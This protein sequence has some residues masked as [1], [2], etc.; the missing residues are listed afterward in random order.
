MWLSFFYRQLLETSQC[1]FMKNITLL[2]INARYTH[3]NLALFYMREAIVDLP[4]KVNLSEESINQDKFKILANL[5]ETEPQIVAIS[6]YIWNREIVEFLLTSL[7]KINPEI[8]VVL[9]GPEA[10]YNRSYWQGKDLQAD[11][12]IVGGG[13]EAWRY[14]ALNDFNL[15]ESYLRIPNK[16]FSKISFPYKSS[17][18]L[19]LENKY[20]YYEASRG[21]PFKCSFCLSS[22]SDQKLEY[23]SFPAIKSE[24]D[25]ILAHNPKIIKFVDRSF[26]ANASISQAIWEYIISLETKTKFH[27]EVHPALFKQRDYE[28]LDKCPPDRIQFE[29]GIQSTNPKTIT[30]INRNHHFQDYRS[31][32]EKILKIRNIHSHLDLIIGL[33]YEDKDSFLNSL[34]DLLILESDVIQLGFLKVLPA[35][36]MAEKREEYGLEYDSFPP[37]QI[38]QTKWLPF[39]DMQFFLAFEDMFNHIYNSS[40]L[41]SSLK[42]I[43]SYLDRPVD[44]FIHFNL[45]LQDR[46]DITNSNWL[47][48]FAVVREFI[49]TSYPQLN[50]DLVDD[51]L[52]WDW[53]RHSR[54]N[55]LPSFLDRE[56]NHLFKRQIFSDLKSKDDHAWK[57]ILGP[58]IKNLNNCAFFIPRTKDFCQKELAGKTRVLLFNPEGLAFIGEN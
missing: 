36:E 18:F 35:T 52:S 56:E 44:F 3:S 42:F 37:Y 5:V 34:N 21:C 40:R 28:I 27:F 1:G 29:I 14:L 33:P 49:H 57:E 47:A 55:N 25:I 16:A 9:G 13:E 54:K 8:I 2:G 41:K 53:L 10:G 48:L 6:T 43:T 22:R 31:K 32:L 11:Y 45:F 20:I 30:A 58:H 15:A 7:K 39:K 4:Y 24:L 50:K 46:F 19:M 51:Y 12:I 17:D 38:L 23:K 26:N